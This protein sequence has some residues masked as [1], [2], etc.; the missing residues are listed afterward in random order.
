MLN[1]EKV[2]KYQFG[3]FIFTEVNNLIIYLNVI[4]TIIIIIIIITRNKLRAEDKDGGRKREKKRRRKEETKNT[5]GLTSSS[6]VLVLLKG[7]S[8][9]IQFHQYIYYYTLNNNNR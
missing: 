3:N 9:S 1:E 5:K 4:I 2:K 6:K 8:F 7:L